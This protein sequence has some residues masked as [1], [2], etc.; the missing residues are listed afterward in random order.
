MVW[1]CTKKT[2]W[3]VSKEYSSRSCLMR[4]GNI[5]MNTGGHNKEIHDNIYF[6]KN[7]M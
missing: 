4:E 5:I 6:T 3:G 1:T 7:L 2:T